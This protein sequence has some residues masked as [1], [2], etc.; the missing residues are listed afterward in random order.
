[1]ISSFKEE[2]CCENIIFSVYYGK[3]GPL[4][5]LS[6]VRSYWRNIQ[7][8]TNPQKHIHKKFVKRKLRVLLSG[9][10]ER[11][12]VMLRNMEDSYPVSNPLLLSS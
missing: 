9:F 1:M 8:E 7:I 4:S 12:G 11:R 3:V 5:G 2:G 10:P 6:V